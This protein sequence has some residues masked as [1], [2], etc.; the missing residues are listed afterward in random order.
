MSSRS[1]E[2][3]VLSLLAPGI[4]AAFLLAILAFIGLQALL[5]LQDRRTALG[6]DF[7]RYA[8]VGVLIIGV[9]L[10]MWGA[11]H[12]LLRGTSGL[13]KRPASW[14]RRVGRLLAGTVM[15]AGILALGFSLGR[16][17]PAPVDEMQPQVAVPLLAFLLGVVGAVGLVA[18]AKV[19]RNRPAAREAR[20][21]R[22]PPQEHVAD[23][24]D[25]R[26]HSR[27]DFDPYF[28]A[29]CSCGWTGLPRDDVEL[30]KADARTHRPGGEP[31]VVRPLA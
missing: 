28:A 18:A 25:V 13:G 24:L 11:A 5:E 22:L 27:D 8:F 16:S 26:P 9:W 3:R 29:T 7:A 15:V 20:Q 19:V 14:R 12:R 10:A 30:A 4:G 2:R 17:Q 21:R 23:V 1:R 31:E 6:D